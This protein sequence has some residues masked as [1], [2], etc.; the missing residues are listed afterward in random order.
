MPMPK[1]DME[2][3]GKL[4]QSDKDFRSYLP[5][6]LAQFKKYNECRCDT[7]WQ[8]DDHRGDDCE[9]PFN[10][11]LIKEGKELLKR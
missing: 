7:E 1:G 9:F 2:Y 6:L 10:E 5:K 3:V 4:I 11:D 8:E